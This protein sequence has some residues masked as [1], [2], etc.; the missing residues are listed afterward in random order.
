VDPQKNPDE[1]QPQDNTNTPP[2]D[3]TD[4]T[5]GDISMSDENNS[6][7]PGSGGASN[8]VDAST[9]DPAAPTPPAPSPTPVSEDEMPAFMKDSTSTDVPQAPTGGKKKLL[10]LIVG[11]V[12]GI[13]LLGGGAAAYYFGYMVPNKPQNVLK[14][15]L[16]NSFSTE[17]AKSGSFEGS[18]SVKEEGSDDTFSA[19][20][21]GASD[22]DGKFTVSASIDAIVT[23]VTVDVRSLDGK[24]LYAKVGG[25]AGLPELMAQSGNEMAAMYAP[26]LNE[27]NDQWFEINDSLLKETTG[28][29]TNFKLSDADRQKLAT[30]YEENQFLTVKETLASEKING[31]DSH[32]YKV[33]IDNDKLQGFVSA[34]E[35]AK[36]ESFGF[37]PEMFTG[38]KDSLKDA[39]LSQY[40]LDVWIAK[41]TKLFTQ[42]SFAM[43]NDEGTFNFR[44][45]FKDY[46]KEFTVE[47]PEGAKP[48]IDLLNSFYESI[49]GP[50]VP[51][52]D[53]PA[54]L[55]G[56]SL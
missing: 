5:A 32:H 56:I 47:K 48:I 44:M 20:F 51:A 27:V 38:I 30:A 25:L 15:A 39:N 13:L 12:A 8:V 23:K 21:S 3:G 42:V 55:Q 29:S 24:T 52:E 36:I 46:N 43:Q 33:T 35:A 54:E 1:N 19:D 31:T 2:S 26:L 6:T 49:L 18:L 11:V 40:P 4:K 9:P 50:G 37:T 34:V 41:D 53:L 45:A 28:T 14:T 7:Q 16:V 17:K 10:G 22:Q